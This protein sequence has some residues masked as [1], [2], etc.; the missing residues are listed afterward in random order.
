VKE[1]TTRAGIVPNVEKNYPQ[2]FVEK[3]K[4]ICGI[5]NQKRKEVIKMK[6]YKVI[7]GYVREQ[8][9]IVEANSEEEAEEIA[10]KNEDN[11]ED[12]WT[13]DD[14]WQYSVEEIK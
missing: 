6:Y 11:F 3:L 9:Q 10:R 7:R 4:I 14:D 8:T 1:A 12:C 2:A 13:N 5:K